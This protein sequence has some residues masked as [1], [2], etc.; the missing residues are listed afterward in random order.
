MRLLLLLMINSLMLVLCSQAQEKRKSILAIFP[1][2]DDETAVG[3][4]LSKYSKQHNVYIIY[5]VDDID[6]SGLTVTT[7]GDTINHKKIAEAKCSCKKLGAEPIFLGM[8]R[9]APDFRKG[10][11][12][13]FQKIKKLK[14]VLTEKIQSINPDVIITFGPDGE[15][16]H[17]E[18]RI[19]S[20][21]VT[22]LILY[23]GWVDRYP[24]Y[25]MGWPK[26]ENPPEQLSG[27]GEV[28]EKYLSVAIHF[29]NEDEATAFES[30]KC[31]QNQFSPK[32]IQERKDEMDAD[33]ANIFYFRQ[34]V[35][36]GKI[37][38]DLFD[39]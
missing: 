6:T 26:E 29:S 32:D 39:K 3:E 8:G 19:T 23:N 35:V 16:G 33:K 25:F 30:L 28:D 22:E 21:M 20:S 34:F 1:H 7:E 12:G 27:T 36:S 24:L 2:S 10:P 5:I 11:R 31:Y 15:S 37:K 18:H 38:K 9:L 17:F 14:A 4:V 13:Y